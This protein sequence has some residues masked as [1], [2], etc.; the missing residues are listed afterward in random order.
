MTIGRDLGG[1]QSGIGHP[2][3]R[4]HKG[5]RKEIVGTRQRRDERRGTAVAQVEVVFTRRRRG[6]VAVFVAREDAVGDEIDVF[7]VFARSEHALRVRVFAGV[8]DDRKIGEAFFFGSLQVVL[9]EVR[10]FGAAV[11]PAVNLLSSVKNTFAPLALA[12]Q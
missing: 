9:V 12:V 10:L 11:E 1:A 8:F 3:A 5:A 7:A 4:A 6:F 2:I